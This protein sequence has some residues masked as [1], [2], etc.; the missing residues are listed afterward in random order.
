MYSP[1]HGGL[2]L[3]PF[4]AGLGIASALAAKL[5]LRI[6]PRWLVMVGGSIAVFGCVTAFALVQ[7]YPAY[8]PILGT[9]VLGI[10]FGVGFAVIPLTLS[11]VA[12]VGSDD[13]GPLTALAQVAQN[14]GGAI[15]LVAVGG[16]VAGRT[17]ATELD[18][19]ASGYGLAILC[20]GGLAVVAVLVAS[21]IRFTSDDIS[22]GQLA[23]QQ[24]H[25]GT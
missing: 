6:A 1:L 4:A 2:A 19:V 8:F 11:I 21:W 15:G 20:A 16:V 5:A 7:S 3:L 10:G 9:L 12:G 24:A 18:S 25:A 22:E 23:Q 13:I 17:T 14:L